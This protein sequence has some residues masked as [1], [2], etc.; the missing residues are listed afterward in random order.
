MRRAMSLMRRG[1]QGEMVPRTAGGR[2]SEFDL[3]GQLR[4]GH[5]ADRVQGVS[6][7]EQS[8]ARQLEGV[9]V[10]RIRGSTQRQRAGRKRAVLETC[11]E[12]SCALATCWSAS[13][14]R[15]SRLWWTRWPQHAERA[16]HRS[17]FTRPAL[18]FRPTGATERASHVDRACRRGRDGA[19]VTQRQRRASRSPRAE[20][21]R[22]QAAPIGCPGRRAT[23]PRSCRAPTRRPSRASSA[24][25]ETSRV[26][27]ACDG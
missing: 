11:C 13:L 27:G 4:R 14:D 17:E 2:S 21:S 7:T 3:T 25:E 12:T 10:D 1:G 26:P 15:A 19:L 18:M 5:H 22:R 24:S 23:A 20:V 16:G 6:T 8:T 9:A